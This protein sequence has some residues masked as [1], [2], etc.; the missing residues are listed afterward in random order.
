MSTPA[1]LLER[2]VEAKD[3]NRPKLAYEIY[4]PDAVLTFSIATDKIDFPRR[5]EGADGV[6]QTLIVDFARRF[7]RCKTFYVCAT[8]P[9]LG[10]ATVVV[11][12]LVLMR[13]EATRC[14]RCGMGYYEWEFRTERL[15]R[16]SEPRVASMHIHIHRMDPI[17]DEDGALLAAAQS[18]LRYPWLPPG[19]LYE[20]FE[21]R[22]RIDSALRF[23]DAFKRPL[24]LAAGKPTHA[25]VV[26]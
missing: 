16:S 11:P 22:A 9:E 6:V 12:W 15:D 19:E 20:A 1:L 23:L 8:P 18:G 3:L 24:D 21:A 7:S 25:G 4:A 26:P 2:Y 14:M 13:E 10:E 17:S 5:V